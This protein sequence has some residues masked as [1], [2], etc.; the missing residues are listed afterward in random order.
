VLVREALTRI[1][2]YQADLIARTT[3]G[4]AAFRRFWA[5][6]TTTQGLAD[7]A[8]D[9][10]RELLGT[11]LGLKADSAADGGFVGPLK[12]GPTVVP[13]EL[14]LTPGQAK[15]TPP[16]E[17]NLK[18]RQEEDPGGLHTMVLGRDLCVGNR[19]SYSY[20]K[21]KNRTTWGGPA[22]PGRLSPVTFE[23]AHADA[24][25]AP[26][27]S[28]FEACLKLALAIAPNEGLL[29]ACRAA[30][31]GMIS[32]G[33][34]QW[35][36]HTN[37]EFP[38][39]LHR[40]R[41]LAADHYDLFFGL[42]GLQPELW[43]PSGSNPLASYRGDLDPEDLP[44]GVTLDTQIAKANPD[45]SVST[46]FGSDYPTYC[47]FFRLKPGE[48]PK[49]MP[50]PAKFPAD[51]SVDQRAEYFGAYHPKDRKGK[52]QTWLI[53]F[54]PEWS[55]RIRLAALCS[56]DYCAAQ[57]QLAS[58]RMHRIRR[59]IPTRTVGAV[60]HQLPELISS[61][62]VAAMVLDQ[63][64]NVPRRVDDDLNI[65]IARTPF[66]THQ[67]PPNEAKLRRDWLMRF[68]VNYLAV[69]WTAG[70]AKRN[71]N[72]LDLHDDGLDSEPESF[73]GW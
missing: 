50:A 23:R 42:H 47:T 12:I 18:P 61:Q 46:Q 68:A 41:H 53:E 10:A 14:R 43:A 16:A 29:D 37:T 5:T 67:D 69:R 33:V 11:A 51:I 25:G 1:D 57:L 73:A 56:I 22:Y 58:Y 4:N 60:S 70:G 2:E 52:K 32:T 54:G 24:I 71:D 17:S 20:G 49:R 19:D 59:E 38:V 35:S 39:L 15:R 44:A 62:F 72:I 3:A 8:A 7:S 34:H 13:E 66:P 21:G 45:M 40:F 28:K 36:V 65:A 6:L 26:P 55:G 31:A 9:D 30:D 48:E 63:H 64:I 27:N